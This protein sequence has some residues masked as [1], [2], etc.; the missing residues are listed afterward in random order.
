MGQN[1]SYCAQI[2]GGHQAI[3]TT[4]KQRTPFFWEEKG[5]LLSKKEYPDFLVHC[6]LD[7]NK[8]GDMQQ[9]F[10]RNIISDKLTS[11]FELLFDF[12]ATCAEGIL[13]QPIQ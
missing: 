11:D 5:P 9:L 7:N 12:K 13:R 1:R 6:R 10:S 4:R 3:Q 8:F 2:L